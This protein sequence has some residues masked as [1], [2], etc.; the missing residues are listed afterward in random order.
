MSRLWSLWRRSLNIAA[1]GLRGRLV[2]QQSGTLLRTER[3]SSH[4][5]RFTRQICCINRWDFR[6]IIEE[7]QKNG[8]QK[9]FVQGHVRRYRHYPDPSDNSIVEVYCPVAEGILYCSSCSIPMTKPEDFGTETDGSPNRDYCCYCYSEGALREDVTMEELT[10]DIL[11]LV[12]IETAHPNLLS[13][14]LLDY[15][16]T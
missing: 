4:Y 14:P 15:I 1:E 9:V 13:D 11:K 3:R 2:S 7:E 10:A 12:D 6:F 5:G 16:R 8:K